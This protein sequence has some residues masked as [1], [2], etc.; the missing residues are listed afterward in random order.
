M[1]FADVVIGQDKPTDC[2]C[3]DARRP[4]AIQLT[5]NG[6]HK[7]E[8]R[9]E[10]FYLLLFALIAGIAIGVVGVYGSRA[11]LSILFPP[12]PVVRTEA[13]GY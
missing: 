1:A 12:E 3:G 7:N 13:D 8:L 11:L 4:F 5:Y 6:F 9:R 2:S 10:I